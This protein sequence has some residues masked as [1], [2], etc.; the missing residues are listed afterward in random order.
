MDNKIVLKNKIQIQ[1]NK[2]KIIK[3]KIH[4]LQEITIQNSNNYNSY[5]INMI[6]NKRK[7]MIFKNKYNN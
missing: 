2:I 3:I 4:I 1:T 6:N 5:L 7:L